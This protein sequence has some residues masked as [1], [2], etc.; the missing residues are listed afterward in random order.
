VSV[1]Q[2]LERFQ[3]KTP[4]GKDEGINV[5]N[6]A[7]LLVE[8]VSDTERIKEER[9]KV[10]LAVTRTGTHMYTHKHEVNCPERIIAY[11][12]IHT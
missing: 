3:Y 8:L 1:I 2:A 5:R 12:A 6:R 4:K 7:K 11:A 10:L 9:E